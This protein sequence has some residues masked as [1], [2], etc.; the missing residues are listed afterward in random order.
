MSSAILLGMMWVVFETSSMGLPSA[1]VSLAHD[2]FG[3]F[4]YHDRFTFEPWSFS[5]RNVGATTTLR[6]HYGFHNSPER[7]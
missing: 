3:R 6:L 2:S 7:I 4:L 1:L 5:S